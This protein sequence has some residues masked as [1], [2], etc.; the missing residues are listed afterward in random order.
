MFKIHEIRKNESTFILNL[1]IE[2]CSQFHAPLI[3]PMS[4]AVVVVA[5]AFVVVVVVV[6]VVAIVFFIFEPFI[7]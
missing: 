4:F 5:A 1:C 3:L 2:G 6:I 7:C